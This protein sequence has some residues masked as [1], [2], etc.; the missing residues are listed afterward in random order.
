MSAAQS[1]YVFLVQVTAY[2]E[3]RI[4]GTIGFSEAVADKKDLTKVRISSL[5]RYLT[6]ESSCGAKDAASEGDV[7]GALVGAAAKIVNAFDFT[8]KIVLV[9]RR[10]RIAII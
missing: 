2:G 3:I 1:S 6:E 10:G 9:R 5:M 4:T 8:L 7:A